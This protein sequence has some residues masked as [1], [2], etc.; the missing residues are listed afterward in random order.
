MIVQSNHLA[1]PIVA[2]QLRIASGRLFR[3]QPHI[4]ARSPRLLFKAA[5]ALDKAPICLLKAVR[6]GK[7]LK[8]GN[9][10][11]GSYIPAFDGLRTLCIS[12]VILIH[13][14]RTDAAWLDAISRRGWYG[15]DVFFVLS[16]FLI[17]W[18]LL[19]ETDREGSINLPRFYLRRA[20]RL[21]PAYISAL[22]LSYLSCLALERQ[23]FRSALTWLPYY[24]TYTFNFAFAYSASSAPLPLVWSL[25]IEEQFYLAWPWCLRKLSARRALPFLIGAIAVIALYRTTYYG[26]LNQGHFWHPSLRT[27]HQ[28]YFRTDTRIDT[29]LVGCALALSLRSQRLRP[30]WQS[31]TKAIW[32]PTPALLSCMAVTWYVTDGV[33][34]GHIWRYYT[35]GSTVTALF[36]GI[37][38]V[39]LFLQ[40]ASWLSRSLS[41]RPMVFIGKVSYGI[42]LFHPFAWSI[43]S[44][45]LGL[46]D[47]LQESVLA[48]MVA[49]ASTLALSTLI[50]W[51]HYRIVESR[52]L[53]LRDR[54][55]FAPPPTGET[56]VA[57]G[58]G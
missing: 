45:V 43:A 46:H 37:L 2:D 13:V 24:L 40:P 30:L 23:V 38:I 31:L 58:Q 35:F 55:E 20:L 34:Q 19:G 27:Y 42:Y 56:L 4:A 7:T 44:R 33:T 25:C 17:T 49:F 41:W 1:A 52:F 47:R 18:V 16:G 11:A 39:A 26:W 6:H 12:G 28:L 51:L 32:F 10:S 8:P 48:S 5:F 14:V 53:A 22:C 3:G 15:V 21:Q 9:K 50:A 29:I 57:A 36:W 54:I